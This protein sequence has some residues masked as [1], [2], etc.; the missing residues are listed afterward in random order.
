MPFDPQRHHRH[1]IRLKGWDYRSA[2]IYYVTIVTKE[3]ACLFGNVECGRVVLNGIGKIVEEEWL[4]TPV[5]RPYVELDEF[6][7]MP[8]HLHGIVVIKDVLDIQ[9]VCESGGEVKTGGAH[10]CALKRMPHSLG[11]IIAGF[12]SASAKRINVYRNSPGRAV[13]HRNYYEHIVHDYKSL[14][15]IR[16]YIA[17]NPMKWEMS[18]GQSDDFGIPD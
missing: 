18:K 4:E 6:V 1:S 16:Q 14:E 11:S 7:I 5:I 9:D 2:C 10:S 8:N 15:R 12:K 13:W 17:N 3:N